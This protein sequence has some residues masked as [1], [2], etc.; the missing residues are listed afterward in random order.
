MALSLEAPWRVK[1]ANRNDNI[2]IMYNV[3]LKVRLKYV[4][5]RLRHRD[6][7]LPHVLTRTVPAVLGIIK[8]RTEGQIKVQRW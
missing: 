1:Y 4:D 2:T 3:F 8:C 7:H 6:L 5:T